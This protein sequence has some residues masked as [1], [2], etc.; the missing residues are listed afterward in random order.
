VGTTVRV[1]LAFPPDMV[2]EPVIYRV[3]K[4]H[5]LVPS[6]RQARVT[7]AS[8]EAVLDFSGAE[9]DVER[10]LASLAARGVTVTRLHDPHGR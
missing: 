5:H 3:A 6:I 7:E 8:G 10:G 2:R 4:A 9:E 1:H